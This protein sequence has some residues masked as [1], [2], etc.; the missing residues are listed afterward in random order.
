MLNIC[1]EYTN[2]EEEVSML[3]VCLKNGEKRWVNRHE[4][5]L[6]QRNGQIVFVE[7]IITE[8]ADI[9]YNL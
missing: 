2:Q 4:A 5:S 7:E 6:L 9:M 1:R 8:D 3:N